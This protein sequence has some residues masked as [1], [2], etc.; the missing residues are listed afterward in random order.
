MS[1][2]SGGKGPI[3]II[4]RGKSRKHG[5]EAVIDQIARLKVAHT[6]EYREERERELAR[7]RGLEERIR[8]CEKHR[9]RQAERAAEAAHILDESD[10]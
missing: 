7:T 8:V 10:Y 4:K 3:I 2:R 5:N 6:K 1:R 9:A